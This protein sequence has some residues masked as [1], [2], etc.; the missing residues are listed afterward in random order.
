MRFIEFNFLIC[1]AFLALNSSAF[2]QIDYFPQE[3]TLCSKKW[4]V[5]KLQGIKSD[6]YA[7]DELQFF[8]NRIFKAWR[9]GNEFLDGRWVMDSKTIV[10]IIDNFYLLDQKLRTLPAKLKVV[11]ISEKELILKINLD[12][13]GK[14]WLQ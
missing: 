7:G 6:F 9:N 1:L 13:R 4:K 5:V 11:E 2:A 3:K 14:V 12:E 10:I 8:S